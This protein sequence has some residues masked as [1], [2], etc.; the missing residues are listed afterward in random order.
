MALELDRLLNNPAAKP[1]NSLVNLV[2]LASTAGQMFVVAPENIESDVYLFDT[3]GEEEATLESEITDNWVEDNKTMQDHIG[4]KP[5]TITLS[6]YVGELTNK[7]PES[8]K[9]L[10]VGIP[11]KLS[12]LSPFAPKLTTQ[13]QYILNRA[14]EVYRIYEKANRP[15]DR[16][17]D[18]LNNISVPEDVPNQQAVFD[19]FYQMWEARRLCT[20][21]TPFG[22]F[23][24]MAIL[25]VSARQEEDSAY[26]SEFTVKFKKI[27]IA[28][29]MMTYNNPELSKLAKQ[30]L[31]S[32]VD[33]GIKKPT[34]NDGLLWT[35]K[36]KGF[37]AAYDKAMNRTR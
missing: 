12:S 4:L 24:N 33:K 11:E 28:G 25:S 30:T 6:G 14:Q 35:A 1:F 31:S 20:V 2:D 16:I 10:D 13:T 22:V 3:R 17:E 34:D 15:I 23:D 19:K 32:Q 5:I 36:E 37:Q 7:L 29:Q 18:M 9:G 21:Y 26:I 27:R 8:L